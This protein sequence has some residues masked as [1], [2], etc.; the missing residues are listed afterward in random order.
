VTTL[1]SALFD[2]DFDRYFAETGAGQPLWL[3]V[4][5]PKTAGSSL[6]AEASS[7]LQPSFNIDIDH[8][9]TTRTYQVKFEASVQSFVEAQ[10]QQR[11]RFV[12][13]H[14]NARHV[15]TIRAGVADLRCFTML[16]APIARLISD[17]HYQRS[18]MNTA[19]AQFIAN[20]P[21]LETYVARKHVHNKIALNLAPRPMVEAGDVAGCVD[22][23]MKAYAFVG[24]QE[25]YPLSLR[26]LTTLMGD[27]RVPEA[28]VRVNTEATD[29][30]LSPELEAELRSLNAVDIGIFQAYQAK[31]RNI[32]DDLRE[33]F[34]TVPKKK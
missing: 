1:L 8:T 6:T 21:S 27:Q 13:G 30:S 4:H 23:I 19:Q 3:F 16:R 15:E 9:D 31:W 33:Y 5:V 12:T 18:S 10:A 2:K 11:Y 26:L 29:R 20:T 25:M 28:K 24:L 7:I 17:Y 14:I 34:K 32:R 22:Y